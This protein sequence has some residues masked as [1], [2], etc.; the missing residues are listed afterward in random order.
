MERGAMKLSSTDR[1]WTPGA[2]VLAVALALLVAACGDDGANEV[3]VSG[4]EFAFDVDSDDFVP[5]TN[6]I[7]FEN[8]GEQVHHLQLIEILE[9]H[10]LPELLAAV[11]AVEEGEPPPPWARFAGGVGQIAPGESAS[12]ID[13]LPAGTYALICLVPDPA[14]GVP[15]VA[16]GMAAT[17]TVSG[18]ENDADIPEADI[19]VTGTDDGAGTSYAFAAPTVVDDGELV[20]EFTNGGSEPHEANLIRLE[21]GFTVEMLMEAFAA[22]GPPPQG[23]P[24]FTM[25]GGV[26][27]VFP[28][29]S[30]TAR[31]DLDDGNYVLICYIPNAEGVPHFARGM[32]KEFRAE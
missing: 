23:P 28:G 19:T 15:H 9:G 18:D 2:V 31:L 13:E 4:S 29:V 12:I 26:Q 22:E 5:G 8:D 21:E 6:E 14:D 30:Q 3:T 11:G 1:R 27:A 7:V 16:K 17:V 32:V 10:S 24:P 20:L 25:V